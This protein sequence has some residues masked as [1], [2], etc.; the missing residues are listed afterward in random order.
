MAH[1]LQEVCHGT[2]RCTRGLESTRLALVFVV[3]TESSQSSEPHQ[4]A[5]PAFSRSRGPSEERS[6]AILHATRT[7][8]GHFCTSFL[9]KFIQLSQTIRMVRRHQFIL[10]TNPSCSEIP[11]TCTLSHLPD[12]P[13]V[14]L[15][16]S[17]LV[18]RLVTRGDLS[19]V[20]LSSL[21]S[22]LSVATAS[23]GSR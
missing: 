13:P 15:H 18:F 17:F 22:V 21:Q 1:G 8:K 3:R 5:M 7:A 2:R 9:V 11:L 6:R 16:C 12:V 23:F 10:T 19:V 4:D 14:L 20:V